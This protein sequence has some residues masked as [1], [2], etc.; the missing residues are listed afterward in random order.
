[1]PGDYNGDGKISLA[2]WRPSNGNWYIKGPG[3]GHWDIT[4]GNLNIQ[5]GR[6]EDI[7]VPRDYFNEGK[8]R[9]AVYRASDETLLIKGDDLKSWAT[10]SENFILKLTKKGKL[11]RDNTFSKANNN[12][13]RLSAL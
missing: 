10:S 13:R 3:K 1:M 5:C 12:F 4:S 8:L 6:K 11:P 9:I 2:V 7:P